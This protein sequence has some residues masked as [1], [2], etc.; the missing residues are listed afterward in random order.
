MKYARRSLKRQLLRNISSP[1][2]RYVTAYMVS[3]LTLNDCPPSQ[4]LGFERF[5]QEVKD[6][7]KDHKIQQKVCISKVHVILS[8]I[9]STL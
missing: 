7:L 6:V 8:L 1:H 4:K 5:E 9:H 2:S 3:S